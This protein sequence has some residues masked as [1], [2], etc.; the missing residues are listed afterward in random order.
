[1]L[2]YHPFLNFLP[3]L[4]IVFQPLKPE[5]LTQSSTKKVSKTGNIQPS[6]FEHLER[7][8]KPRK[9]TL[10]QQ[11]KTQKSALRPLITSNPDA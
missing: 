1:M 4:F 10:T 2:P 8:Q 3:Q 11:R 7:K 9:K 6:H 5:A